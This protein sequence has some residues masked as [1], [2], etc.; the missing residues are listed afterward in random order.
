M[1]LDIFTTLKTKWDAARPYVEM[2]DAAFLFLRLIILCGGIIW[3]VFSNIPREGLEDL[4]NLFVCFSVYSILIYLL[5]FFYPEKKRNIHVFFLF[6]DF[7]FTFLLV[8]LTGG[9][10][11]H[12]LIGFYL[13]TAL[14]SFYYGLAPGAAISAVASSLYLASGDFDFT[15]HYWA[16][17]SVSIA[18]LFL[19]AIP[20]GMLSQRL[21][22]D[23]SEIS[24]LNV[25]L[26]NYIVELQNIHG[27]LVQVEKMSELGRMAADVAHE[28]RNPLTSIG[29]FARRLEHELSHMTNEKE[30]VQN[31]LKEKEYAKII[32]AEVN[33]L[34]RILRDILT[35]SKDVKYSMKHQAISGII[36]ESLHIFDEMCADKSIAIEEKIDGSLPDILVD[37]DQARQAVNNLISNAIDAMPRGGTLQLKAFMYELNS[38]NYLVV[39]IADTGCGITEDK[40]SMIF[41]PFY[42]SK[43]IGSGTGLGL[44]ICKKIMDEHCGLIRVESKLG[45]GTSFKLFFPYQSKEEGSKIKC[46]EFLKCGV[47]KTEGAAL[48][49]CPAYPNYGRICWAV[50]GTFC[51][52]K[53]CGAI[54]QKLGDCK[55]C[56]FYNRMVVL[57][58]I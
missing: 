4:S 56:E 44:S 17:I 12:F 46:W 5:L 16:D 15:T 20:L 28:I 37:R 7:L 30:Y 53:V 23:S 43:E 55:K 50:S 25:S 38:V 18:S 51:G 47:E 11:S 9:F 42:S 2:A 33:R 19:V 21:K 48:T 34:E 27:R 58:N 26:K 57:K 41:E 32:I 10:D 36:K 52:G 6:F 8:R 22:R 35:F 3:L 45:R 24:N 40:L 13:M 14:Y 29:G 1:I 39:E 31:I 54:A 49:K